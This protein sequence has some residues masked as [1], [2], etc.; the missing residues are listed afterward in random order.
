MVTG[1]GAGNYVASCDLRIFVDQAVEPVSPQNTQ[2]GHFQGWM[3]AAHGRVLVQRPVRP[4]DVIVI[5]I[6]TKN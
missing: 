3:R 5:D 1:V 6:F 2:T 4:M